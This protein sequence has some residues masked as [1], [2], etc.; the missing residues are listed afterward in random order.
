LRN[1]RAER[2]DR[3][4]TSAGVFELLVD[5]LPSQAAAAERGVDLGVGEGDTSG[6]EL[7]FAEPGQ[8]V[9]DVDLVAVLA[10]VVAHGGGHW[11]PFLVLVD[12]SPEWD[13]ASD[14]VGPGVG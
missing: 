12:H 11:A 7:V 13:E 4:A 6:V 3:Q 10:G 2:Q 14:L 9:G 1:V 8:L 5:Q